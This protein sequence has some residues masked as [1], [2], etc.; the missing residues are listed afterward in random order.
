MQ[1]IEDAPQPQ[2]SERTPEPAPITPDIPKAEPA[3]VPARREVEVND[4]DERD[5]ISNDE[6]Q[7]VLRGQWK[8]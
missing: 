1:K 8:G 3:H 4:N 6:L 2:F 7:Q 5:E